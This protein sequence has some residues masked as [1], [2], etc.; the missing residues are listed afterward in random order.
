MMVTMMITMMSVVRTLSIV[1][2][3]N[4]DH[5]PAVHFLATAG[6]EFKQL[7]H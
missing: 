5:P 1:T 3:P 4:L 2:E 6:G 7:V